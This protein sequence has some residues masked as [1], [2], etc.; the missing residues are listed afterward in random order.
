MET[1]LII[2]EEYCKNSRIESSFVSLLINEG[3]IDVQVAN[4]QMYLYESQLAELDR[5]A[6]LYYDLSVNVE[7][8]DII[9][10]LL[11]KMENM[12]KEL[13]ILRKRLHVHDNL[14]E[15]ID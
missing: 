14:W 9:H 4:G 3:L 5:F 1:G 2:I 10:N 8:I 7:G 6:N 15:G 13:Y 12:E 11:K